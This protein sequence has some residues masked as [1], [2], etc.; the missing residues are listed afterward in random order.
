MNSIAT[1]QRSPFLTRTTFGQP[2]YLV[3]A[4]L[5][6]F[7]CAQIPVGAW[8]A[9]Q[10]SYNKAEDWLPA[11]FAES[12]DLAWFRGHFEGEQFALVSWDGCTLG[13]TEKLDQLS[14]RL[15][16]SQEA[17]DNA[18]AETD[19]SQRARWYQRV[20][21]GPEVIEQL[22]SPPLSLDYEQALARI[23]G[24]FVGPVKRDSRGQSLGDDTRT[25]CLIV[26]LSPA[27]IKNNQIMRQAIH[28]IA[29][30]A[31]TEC[32]IPRESIHMGG[33]SVDN[34]TID[35]ESR[36]STPLF[37]ASAL[38][39]GLFLAYCCLGNFTASVLVLAVG[40]LSAGLSLA[41]VYYYG[42]LEVL[43]G[44]AD[45]PDFG[46]VDAIL[47]S[48][49][50]VVFVLGI[51][52]TIRLISYYRDQQCSPNEVGLAENA[53]RAGWWPCTLSAAMT[54]V[55]IGA[56]VTSDIVPIKKFGIFTS[57]GIVATV[58]LLF[59]IVPAFLHRFPGAVAKQ[60]RP[61]REARLPG[62][63]NDVFRYVIDHSVSTCLLWA[64][65]TGILA[66]GLSRVDTSVHLFKLLDD[67]TDLIQD[68]SW[69][70]ENLGNVVPMELVVTV[71]PERCRTPHEHA[72]SDGEQYRMTM[73]ER[74]EM[75]R[76]IQF[77]VES[78]PEISRALSAATFA[79]ASTF[80]GMSTTAD[81]SADYAVNKSLEEHRATLLASDYLRPE[82]LPNGQTRELWRVSAR[83]AALDNPGNK[84]R[85]IDYGTFVEQLRTAVDPV[86]VAYQ[87]RD[88]IVQ[89]L[90]KMGKQLDGAH[91][92]ILYRTPNNAPEPTIATQES[93]LANLLLK[94]G[95]YPRTLPDGRRLRG[96]TFYNLTDFDAHAE[97]PRYLD[98]AVQA[99]SAQDALILV[100][101]G[102][103]PTAKK[104]ADGG[105]NII[106]VTKVPVT[107]RS[108]AVE[109]AV[110]DN[111][112]PM[113]SVYTGIVPLIYKT[114]RQ[115]LA[116]LKNSIFWAVVA[117]AG[118]MMLVL[119]SAV[120]GLATLLPNV[121]PLVVI[122]GALGW[123]GI[124]VDIGIMMCAAVALGIAI[125]GS[126]HFI[127]WFRRGSHQGLNRREAVSFAYEHC[128]LAMVQT[129]IIGGLALAVFSFSSFTPTHQF[130][131][132][133]VSMLTLAMIGD[134]LILPAMLAGPLG[135]YF[136][137]SN[138]KGEAPYV[139]VDTP[140]AEKVSLTTTLTRQ[141]R[142]EIPVQTVE[143][144][145]PAPKLEFPVVTQPKGPTIAPKRVALA[146]RDNSEVLD[147]PH[148]D[149]HARLR[150]LRRDSS[151][152]RTPS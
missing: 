19:L 53:I 101:A 12:S 113:R 25:T 118:I 137:G 1:Q 111:P 5:A 83:V 109:V 114:Q 122:F 62:W 44:I 8:R 134:L 127:T 54:A 112:R 49:P 110:G 131:L 132:L 144:P 18:S 71:P 108:A 56:L 69:L 82:Y 48:M 88:M 46:T 39:L 79:P 116:T 68:Y 94:S 4:L 147:G 77:R 61:R 142:I 87:Q 125:E 128:T 6:A 66:F 81:R 123:A 138:P 67:D 145:L 151:S 51:S 58:V 31:V 130:G 141:D 152:G 126:I 93:V 120:A 27:A 70:E 42:V 95:V 57:V 50:A 20:F 30:I 26:Y 150:N 21:T 149:L 139:A 80:T 37:A 117:I 97:E 38:V 102:S 40:V 13:N 47:M 143:V 45:Y 32:A 2:N 135:C 73:L 91:L 103:D 98:S 89:S 11:T 104:F 35:A 100:S 59:L 90:H 41:L 3:L 24:A 22:T 15:V 78:F 64:A 72:E 124:K 121:F 52:G 146:N 107:Q 92:C 85:D 119:R 74:L 140:R 96:V 148:A 84:I 129:T 16:P 106:D 43:V 17:L 55:G 7:L 34:V 99:L 86:L 23:E 60:S 10:S 9:L 14:R 65:V 75:I 28:R 76:E 36:R 33:P 105:L 115:L 136:G 29:D 133:M 63:L